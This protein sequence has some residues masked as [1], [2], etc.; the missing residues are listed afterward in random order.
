MIN[1]LLFDFGDIFVNLRKDATHKAFELLGLKTFTP[2]LDELN[3]AFEVGAL[4]EL[5]FLEGFQKHLPGSDLQTIRAAWN[6]IIGEFPLYRLEFLQLLKPKYRLFLLSNTD[7]IHIAHFEQKVGLSF[8]RDF[9]NCFE[10]VYFSYE[11]GLRKP[12][13]NCFKT[14]LS[15]HDLQP[16]NTLFIDDKK[17]NTAAAAA[18][19]ISIWHLQVGQEDVVE[20]LDKKIL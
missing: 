1:T 6:E 15:R 2:D 19:G 16:K 11:M 18:L 12:D 9:Y 13:P 20:L 10:K 3:R 8:A 17:E 4:S 14:V 5:Q 7:A